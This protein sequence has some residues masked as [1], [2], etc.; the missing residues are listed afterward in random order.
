MSIFNIFKTRKNKKVSS[1]KSKKSS[2]TLTKKS[3]GMSNKDLCSKK[4]K[5]KSVR[6][7]PKN[8]AYNRCL[9]HTFERCKTLPPAGWNMY[10]SF[11][12]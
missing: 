12:E 10:R 4:Y 2:N 9:K 6:G 7:T 1:S 11:C 5:D 8:W 3:Y